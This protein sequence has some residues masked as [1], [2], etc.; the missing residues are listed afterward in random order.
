[1]VRGTLPENDLMKGQNTFASIVEAK[2]TLPETVISEQ[3]VLII[4]KI[5]HREVCSSYLGVAL[6]RAIMGNMKFYCYAAKILYK[7]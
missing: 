3:S 5:E 6:I 4:A 2:G 7:H 1:M